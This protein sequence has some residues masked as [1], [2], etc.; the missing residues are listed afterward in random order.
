MVNRRG[1]LKIA[2]AYV[3]PLD[4]TPTEQTITLTFKKAGSLELRADVTGAGPGE[5]KP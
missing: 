3:H 2:V 1:L 4:A 5:R